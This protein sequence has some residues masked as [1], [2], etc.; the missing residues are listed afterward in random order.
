MTLWTTTAG[1]VDAIILATICAGALFFPG[2]RRNAALAILATFLAERAALTHLDGTAEWLVICA[3]ELA[4]VVFVSYAVT[5]IPGRALAGLALARMAFI[6]AMT[7]GFVTLNSATGAATVA[8]YL[9]LVIVVMAG[10]K[11]VGPGV[12]SCGNAGNAG[13]RGP[14]S[15]AARLATIRHK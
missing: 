5:G 12:R 8:L 7:A 6:A 13:R 3:T 1:M 14:V 15:L 10:G 4:F 11:S 2:N 9:Q